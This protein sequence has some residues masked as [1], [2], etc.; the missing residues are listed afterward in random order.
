MQD[1]Q[2]YV[3]VNLILNQHLIRS[4]W[5]IPKAF[6]SKKSGRNSATAS[7]VDTVILA[8]GNGAVRCPFRRRLI[9]RFD[10]PLCFGK[11]K[12]A[13]RN[14]R[15]SAVKDRTHKFLTRWRLGR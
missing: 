7:H 2:G 12:L 4:G 5:Y 9:D 15:C 11:P 1:F 3:L 13:N 14:T 8:W 10:D 6:I